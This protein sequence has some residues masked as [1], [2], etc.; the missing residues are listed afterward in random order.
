MI[1]FLVALAVK[2]LPEP[3]RLRGWRPVLIESSLDRRLGDRRLQRRSGDALIDLR[4]RRRMAVAERQRRLVHAGLERRGVG[5]EGLGE[6]GGIDPVRPVPLGVETRK[7]TNCPA[8]VNDAR[9]DY[10]AAIAASAL[11][12][13]AT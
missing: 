4:C 1:G 9:T 6:F 8:R 5:P 12:L 11:A 7:R 10:F 2:A 3:Y 13:R